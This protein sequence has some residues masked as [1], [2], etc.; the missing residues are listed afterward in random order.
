MEPALQR[1]VR[2]EGSDQ[3]DRC[4]HTQGGRLGLQDDY[5]I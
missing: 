2:H 4:S 3:G 5:M 1:E